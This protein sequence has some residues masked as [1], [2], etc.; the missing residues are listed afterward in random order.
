V[1]LKSINN[2]YSSDCTIKDL[3]PGG[4]RITVTPKAVSTVPFLIIVK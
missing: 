4:V 1:F 2:S 3:S